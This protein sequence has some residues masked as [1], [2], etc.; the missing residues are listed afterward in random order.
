[1]AMRRV[2]AMAAAALL[3]ACATAT[4]YQPAHKGG[5]GFSETRIESNRYT[6]SFSGNSLTER[7]EVEAYLLYRAAELTVQGGF[8]HFIVTTR[9]VDPNRKIYATPRTAFAPFYAY[10]SPRWGW[11]PWYDPFWTDQ[12]I[13][14]VTRYTAN[15]E[16]V[17]VK[18]PKP[19]ANPS[20]FDARDVLANLQAKVRL[21]P[22]GK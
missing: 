4:L 16:I 21:P 11:R 13:S 19:A 7:D 8:D 6:L 9:A 1:M 14:E 22:P 12:T 18:G 2:I 17:M 10:Y 15:A 5:F 20:A 3:A